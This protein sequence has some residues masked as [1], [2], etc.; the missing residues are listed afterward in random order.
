MRELSDGFVITG[1]FNE[2]F[3]LQ[4]QA[5]TGGSSAWDFYHARFNDANQLQWVV[6]SSSIHGAGIP[7]DMCISSTGRSAVLLSWGPDFVLGSD[8]LLSMNDFDW[9]ILCFAPDGTLE[10]HTK[11][12][13][14]QFENFDFGSIAFDGQDRLWIAG[15]LSND[16]IVGSDTIHSSAPWSHDHLTLVLDTSGTLTDHL[17]VEGGEDQLPSIFSIGLRAAL[18]DGMLWFGG[19]Q[20]GSV[21]DGYAVDSVGDATN[22]LVMRL[23]ESLE[24]DWTATFGGDGDDYVTA[25]AQDQSDESIY[26]SLKLI[27]GTEM[28]TD[29]FP[30]DGLEYSVL[31]KMASTGTLLNTSELGHTTDLDEF[32]QLVV[33]GLQ[34]A[35]GIVHAYGQCIPPTG[36]N[37]GNVL[38]QTSFL[39]R[40]DQPGTESVADVEERTAG[41]QTFPSPGEGHVTLKFESPIDG[42]RTITVHDSRGGVVHQETVQVIAGTAHL[43]L[44]HLSSGI[45]AIR[46]AS[47]SGS[48]SQKVVI[49]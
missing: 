43:D 6:N 29:T 40:F 30:N 49:E 31:L 16:M 27:G 25:L 11:L 17:Q 47:K 8:T 18:P 39:A 9:M 45:Y 36:F 2:P 34:A 41:L 33:E 14:I 42:A 3:D 21:I 38:D 5:I 19:C 26:A 48:Y 35:D 12:R 7:N 1:T 24:V 15:Q 4:G 22:G 44:S 37:N 46:S 28:G 20:D 13:T 10:W 32:E 23:N